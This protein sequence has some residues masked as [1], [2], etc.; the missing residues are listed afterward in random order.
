[1][2]SPAER[3]RLERIA[4]PETARGFVAARKLLRDTASALAPDVA[5]G[6]WRFVEGPNGKPVIDP[7]GPGPATLRFNVAHT[8]GF[9]I[10]AASLDSDVGVDA[11][12]KARTVDPDRLI[13]RYFAP[14]EKA[15]LGELAADE[16]RRRFFDVWVLKE[17]AIKLRAGALG[18]QIGTVEVVPGVGPVGLCPSIS[19]TATFRRWEFDGVVFALAV[20]GT[21]ADV[22]AGPWRP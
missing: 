1:M 17:A 20:D 18:S 9:A 19:D 12:N 4:H 3:D 10:A 21:G 5:P 15:W 11:E 22:T 6:A 13:G 2:L 7:N 8:E 14:A 16:R